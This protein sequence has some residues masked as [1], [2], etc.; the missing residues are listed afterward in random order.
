MKKYLVVRVSDCISTI[1]KGAFD[2]EQKATTYAELSNEIEESAGVTYHVA[3]IKQNKGAS[4][5]PSKTYDYGSSKEDRVD[6]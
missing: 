2:D 5:S 6:N 4:N 3:V 1:I